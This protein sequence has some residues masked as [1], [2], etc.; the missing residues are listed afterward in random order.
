[1]R[2]NWGKKKRSVRKEIQTVR[3]KICV[4]G[5]KEVKGP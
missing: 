4:G 1:M 3:E 5:G 2:T